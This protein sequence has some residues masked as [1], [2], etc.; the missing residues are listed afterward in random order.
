MRADRL[1]AILLLLQNKGRATAQSLAEEL[2]VSV[3]TIYRDIDALCAAGIPLYTDRGPGGGISLL[4]SYRTNLTGLT[5]DEISALFLLSI[6]TPL[7]ELG[8]R[9]QINGALLKLRASLPA[10]QSDLGNSVYQRLHLDWVGWNQSEENVPH[11]RS[12]QQA[13]WQ[14]WMLNIKYRSLIR[15]HI[16]EQVIAPYS[17]V[18]KAGT[19]YLVGVIGNRKHVYWV[20][21]IVDVTQLTDKF[22]RP[23]SYDLYSYWQKWCQHHDERRT[24]YPVLVRIDP[25]LLPYLAYIFGDQI[26]DS[27]TQLQASNDND[28]IS[29][30]LTF[31]SYEVA[32]SQIL[33]CGRAIEVLEPLALRVGVIDYAEQIVSFYKS[34]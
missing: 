29:I 26:K 34:Q 19:W 31:E 20:S 6:P 2:E 3:R 5:Q 10:A 17:L 8:Y 18:A 1:L 9:N 4:D 13:V 12:I 11:L 23:T 25:K 14:N 30:Q 32:R 15:G 16:V 21:R 22:E 27:D 7:A 24:L 33:S 28:W